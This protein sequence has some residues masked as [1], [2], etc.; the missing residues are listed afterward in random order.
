MPNLSE[1][2]RLSAADKRLLI[3]SLAAV[4]TFRVA[5][6]LVP[7]RILRT[8]ISKPHGAQPRRED[9]KRIAWAVK[10]VAKRVPRATCLTQAL[11]AQSLIARAGYEADIRIGVAMDQQR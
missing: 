7:Y 5:L 10:K 1:V 9:P 6:Y 4:V 2:L 3:R 11:A 8:W